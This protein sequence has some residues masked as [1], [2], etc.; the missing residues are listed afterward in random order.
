MWLSTLFDHIAYGSRVVRDETLD[1]IH[2]FHIV[3][4]VHLDGIQVLGLFSKFIEIELLDFVLNL[5][6][7]FLCNEVAEAKLG[8]ELALRVD[9]DSLVPGHEQRDGKTDLFYH[10]ANII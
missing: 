6:F 5:L 2:V 4:V 10:F 7:D 9:S 1:L 8:A 3:E